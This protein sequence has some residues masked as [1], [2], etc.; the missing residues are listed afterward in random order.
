MTVGLVRVWLWLTPFDAMSDVICLANLTENV[1][2][3]YDPLTCAATITDWS[4]ATYSNCVL[5]EPAVG[6]FLIMVYSGIYTALLVGIICLRGYG[7]WA[8]GIAGSATLIVLSGLQ[9]AYSTQGLCVRFAANLMEL[10][11]SLKQ[12]LEQQV[13]TDGSLVHLWWNRFNYS[14]WLIQLF[15]LHG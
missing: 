4:S 13:L 1:H 11:P 7:I 3:S 6:W 5:F 12:I 14:N 15:T 2:A 9:S 10:S 8:V